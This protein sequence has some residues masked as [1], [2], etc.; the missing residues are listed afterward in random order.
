M[1]RTKEAA[2]KHGG[3]KVNLND[4][5][6]ST[7][8]RDSIPPRPE[9]TEYD[10]TI[11]PRDPA[12]LSDTFS[13]GIKRHY[14]DSSSIEQGDLHLAPRSFRD[15]TEFGNPRLAIELPEF[16]KS[17]HRPGDDD[18]S[19]CKEAAAPHTIV[20]ASS[21]IRVAD[22]VRDLRVFNSS[23]SK[24]GKYFAK[25]MKLQP[26][27]KFAKQT[28]VGIAVGT[29]VRLKELIEN[30]GIQAGSLQRIIIDGSYQNEKKYTIFDMADSFRAMLDLLNMDGVKSRLLDDKDKLLIMVY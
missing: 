12:L 24:I 27:L 22:L 26:N 9:Q 18:P 25:H 13:Q 2:R 17:F 1:A 7:S 10:E 23:E 4:D 6:T 30:D 11:A 20:I 15:T 16:I 14:G 5:K 8:K 29:P 21:G 3:K 28:R 19:T